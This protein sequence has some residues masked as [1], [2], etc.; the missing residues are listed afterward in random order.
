MCNMVTDLSFFARGHV[1]MH[2]VCLSAAGT[3][4]FLRICRWWHSITE[5]KLSSSSVWTPLLKT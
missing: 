2:D 5:E 3:S 1:C 4:T